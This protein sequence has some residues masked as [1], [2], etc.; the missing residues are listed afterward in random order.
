MSTV[1]NT[2]DDLQQPEK[3]QHLLD[4]F[5]RIMVHYA[6]WFSEVRNR[7]GVEKAME[8]LNEATRKSFSI[9]MKRFVTAF[10]GDMNQKIPA[11]L[12]KMAGDQMDELMQSTAINWLAND[13]VW[14]Q[15]VEFS[16]NM[17]DA[18]ACNDACWVYFSPFEARAIKGLLD[19]PEN[20]GLDG[21]KKALNFR[22][23]ACINIQSIV[24]ESANSF[25]FQMNECRVQSARKRKNLDDYPCKSA[26]IIEYTNFART[27]DSRIRTE[28]VGCPP[29]KHPEE[30][31]CAWRFTL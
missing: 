23:Y 22:L 29:D 26:G 4:M 2:M 25:V 21:L 7:M 12:L 15:A 9:Q 1:P 11:A 27:I 10:G 19:L 6:L 13:G 30:W 18:K 14:F 5:Q 3:T 17:T 8:I 28:C 20:P 16:S 24:E 31:Y